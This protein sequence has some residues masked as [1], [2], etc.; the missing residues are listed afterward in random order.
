M[1]VTEDGTTFGGYNPK[2]WLGYGD[3][4]DAVSPFLF[5]FSKGALGLGG[6]KPVKLAKCG[7]SGMAI[8]DD[9]GQGPQWV[10]RW[11]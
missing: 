10:G 7:G 5:V 3:W 6:E 9:M 8:I 1:G 2:G 11:K 4:I